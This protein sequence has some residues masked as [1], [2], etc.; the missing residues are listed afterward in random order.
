[1][2]AQNNKVILRFDDA[3]FDYNDGDRVILDDTSFSIRE[4][5]KVTI[6]GQNGAG[7]STMFKLIM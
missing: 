5:T 4:N 3:S 7:K 1:M 6:M 2:D